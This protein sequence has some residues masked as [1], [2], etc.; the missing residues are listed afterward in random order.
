MSILAKKENILRIIGTILILGGFLFSLIL[1]L[2][3]VNNILFISIIMIT[4]IPIILVVFCYK[5]EINFIRSNP[6]I[7]LLILCIYLTLMIVINAILRLSDEF[8]LLFLIIVIR[9]I[10]LIACWNFSF[11]IFKKKKAVF[12]IFGSGYITSSIF[13]LSS[14]L[15]T[16]LEVFLRFSPT[17]IVIMGMCS[18]VLGEIWMKKKGLLNYI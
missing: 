3:I 5:F 4:I 18:V 14:S 7:L 8:N 1:D 10:L 6:N 2:I 9:N 12:I 13:F 11:S 16:K 17:L 15:V